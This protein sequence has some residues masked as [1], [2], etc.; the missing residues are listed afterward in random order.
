MVQDLAF[1]GVVFFSDGVCHCTRAHKQS[2]P[3]VG[4]KRKHSIKIRDEHKNK[5]I[6]AFVYPF[7]KM[8]TNDFLY[9]ELEALLLAS[10][11]RL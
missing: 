11:C 6:H 8:R 2:V 4:A 7:I 5:T 3:V 9:L 10:F 1:C